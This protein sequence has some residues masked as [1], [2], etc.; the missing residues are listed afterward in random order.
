M[1]KITKYLGLYTIFFE[2]N[3]DGKLSKNKDD[4]Y[5]KFKN[6]QIYRYSDNPDILAMLLPSG[7][8]TVNNLMP[9]FESAG[10]KV[11]EHISGDICEEAILHFNEC[12]LHEIHKIVRILTKGSN[13]QLKEWKL[14]EKLKEEKLKL[15]EQKNNITNT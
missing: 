15:K 1:L 13:Q 5:L 7:S 3:T 8:S 11:W 14:K 9:K 2:T 10:I 6:N 4:N 12:D